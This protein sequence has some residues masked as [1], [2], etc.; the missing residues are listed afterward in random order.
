[1]I[2]LPAIDIQGG[3]CVRLKQGVKS[4]SKVYGEDPVQ[5]GQKLAAEGARYLHVVDLD[6]AFEGNSIHQQV[7]TELVKAIPIPV[8][9]G[10]GIRTD[11]AAE[12]YL[13][14]GVSRVIIGSMAVEDPDFVSRLTAQYGEKIAVSVDAKN[15]LVAT[16]G[17]V[18]TSSL[19]AVNFITDMKRR[20]VKT[21]IYTDISRDG[22]LTGPN[23]EELAKVQAIGGIQVIASGGVSTPEDLLQLAEMKVYGAI[24][25]TALYE[26]RITMAQIRAIQEGSYAG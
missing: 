12:A 23:R 16:R 1:M 11:A 17:W 8:E 24:T 18:E 3:R 2:I 7:I 9:V 20:G 15:G 10:G 13:A 4:D 6:G 21:F 25:G 14:A 22:M 19:E 5:M 26:G